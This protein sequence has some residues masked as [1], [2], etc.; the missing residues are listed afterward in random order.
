MRSARRS[1]RSP[2]GPRRAEGPHAGRLH[3]GP[4]R[5]RHHARDVHGRGRSRPTRSPSGPRSSARRSRRTA[6]SSWSGRPSTARRRSRPSTTRASCGSSRSPGPRSA[7]QALP[8]AFLS[9][10]TYPNRAM[11]EGMSAEAVDAPRPRAGAR[12]RPGRLLGPRLGGAAGRRDVRRRRA[13]AVDVALTTVDLVLG[14]APVA[15][16]LCRPPGHHAA[17]SMYGGYCFFNNAAI[18]AEAITQATGERVAILD[19]DYHH[20]NG[21]AADLLAA[22]RRPLRLDPRRPAARLPVL[23]RPR[24]RDRRGRRGRGE[25]Q[26]PAAG[27]R[28]QRRTTSRRPTGPSRRSR[29]SRARWSSCRSASTRTGSTRSATSR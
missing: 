8:R 12:G 22:R 15:Y 5:P 21:S 18:A 2:A 11:F 4:P 14:G 17:R 3:A 29:R 23:P 19:V 1:W 28:D 13:A 26:P 16:G 24:R 20:G 25:P 9:A 10:D 6:A 7:A 27:R